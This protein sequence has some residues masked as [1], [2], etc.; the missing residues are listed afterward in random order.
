MGKICAYCVVVS[1]AVCDYGRIKTIW[2][3]WTRVG[4]WP[5][6]YLPGRFLHDGDLNGILAARISNL[7][8]LASLVSC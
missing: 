3:W 4:I 2:L 5:I 1:C 6:D 8:G 7:D